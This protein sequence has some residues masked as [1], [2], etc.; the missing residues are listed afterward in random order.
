MG[1]AWDGDARTVV[2]PSSDGDS[3]RCI[4]AAVAG[5]YGANLV[6]DATTVAGP[7][8]AAS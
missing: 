5:E 4:V 1:V 3:F 2:P 8:S 6:V 7:R